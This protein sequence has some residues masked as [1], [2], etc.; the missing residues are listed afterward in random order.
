MAKKR[1]L[2]AERAKQ[3]CEY[4]LSQ[5]RVA[6]GPFSIEHIFPKVRGGSNH[7]DNLAYSCDGC[8]SLKGTFITGFDSITGEEERLYNP[9]NDVWSDHFQW[10][11]SFELIVGISPVGRATVQR[12]QLNRSGV[13]RL[14]KVMLVAGLHP[15][16]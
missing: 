14:R 13:V 12:L 10:N 6:I 11:E 4:C 1:L 8:N 3:C 2:V 16:F 7:L 9:R 5:D 15:P